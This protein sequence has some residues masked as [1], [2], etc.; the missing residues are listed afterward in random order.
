MKTKLLIRLLFIIGLF[1]LASCGTIKLPTTSEPAT[2][3]TTDSSICVEKPFTASVNEDSLVEVAN[4]GFILGNGVSTLKFYWQANTNDPLNGQLVI[5]PNVC[6]WGGDFCLT[7]KYWLQVHQNN[8]TA[9]LKQ[10]MTFG[11]PIASIFVYYYNGELT[12]IP[13]ACISTASRSRTL[14]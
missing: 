12:A 7:G 10:G 14:R 5:E 6:I 1:A 2:I 9:T 8:L 13:K 4:K 3:I 11:T